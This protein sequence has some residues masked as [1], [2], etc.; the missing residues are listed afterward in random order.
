LKNKLIGP[1]E[2]G[3]DELQKTVEASSGFIFSVFERNDDTH[4]APCSLQTTCAFS[5]ANLRLCAAG[6]K[7]A[8][9]AIGHMLAPRGQA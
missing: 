4:G 5:R 9:I 2:V 6:G 3:P 1:F 8:R 7:S